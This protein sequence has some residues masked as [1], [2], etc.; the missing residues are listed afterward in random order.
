MLSI[1]I[2]ALLSIGLSISSDINVDEATKLLNEN[3]GKI[4][5]DSE[6]RYD[7]GWEKLGED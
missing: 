3:N 5:V 7:I 6:G 4:I 2:S 1:I